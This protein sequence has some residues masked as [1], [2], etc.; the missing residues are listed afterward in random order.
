[1]KRLLFLAFALCVCSTRCLADVCTAMPT[2]EQLG[3]S[4][5]SDPGCG[6]FKTNADRYITCPYDANYHKCINYSCESMGFT[7]DPGMENN[8]P[9]SQKSAWCKTVIPCLFDSNYTLCTEFLE[10]CIAHECN[11]KKPPE[12][13]SCSAECF[14]RDTTCET[15]TTPVCTDW[16]CNKNDEGINYHCAK[17]EIVDGESVAVAVSCTDP[18]KTKCEPDCTKESCR[19]A[20]VLP[21]HAVCDI[22][23][24]I[25]YS[26][27]K[28]GA[29][30]C[31]KWHCEGTYQQVGDHCES[32]TTC[33]EKTCAAVNPVVNAHGIAPCSSRSANCNIGQSVYTDWACNNGYHC[34]KEE[35]INGV[36]KI[37]SIT[38]NEDETCTSKGGNACKEDCSIQTCSASV[39]PPLNAKCTKNC[40]T[41]DI[42]CNKEEICVDWACDAGFKK[43]KKNG[44]FECEQI[45]CTPSQIECNSNQSAV[46]VADKA[47]CSA[48]CVRTQSDAN[49][50][51]NEICTAWNCIAGYHCVSHETNASGLPKAVSCDSPDKV[52]CYQNCNRK[53]DANIYRYNESNKPDNSS[54]AGVPCSTL[55]S[56]CNEGPKMYQGFVCNVGY[57]KGPTG[58]ECVPDLTKVDKTSPHNCQTGYTCTCQEVSVPSHAH[59]TSSCTPTDKFGITS[60]TVPTAFA[61]DEGYHEITDG[62]ACQQDCTVVPCT[63]AVKPSGPAYCINKCK[64]MTEQ[65]AEGDEV[66]TS[67][68]CQPGY[69]TQTTETNNVVTAVACVQDE[70]ST[71]TDICLEK[72]CPGKV[73]TSLILKN[74]DGKTHAEGIN[75]CTEIITVVANNTT[76]CQDT[77][78]PTDWICEEGY[79]CAKKTIDANNVVSIEPVD[80][81]SSEKNYCQKDV[82]ITTCVRDPLPEN[83]FWKDIN[84]MT[85]AEKADD[86]IYCVPVHA[87]GTEGTPVSMLWLC[88]TPSGEY[89]E[90]SAGRQFL[91][92]KNETTKTCDIKYIINTCSE[93]VLPKN[94]SGNTAAGAAYD[95][96]SSCTIVEQSGAQRTV[97]ENWICIPGFNK[98]CVDAN[99]IPVLDNE[100][101]LITE[102]SAGQKLSCIRQEN[103]T[104]NTPVQKPS[105][106]VESNWCYPVTNGIVSTTGA[107]TDWVCEAGYHCAKKENNIVTPIELAPGEGCYT[108]GGNLCAQTCY[109]TTNDCNEENYPYAEGQLPDNGK[110][111]G[112]GLSCIYKDSS[113]DETKTVTRYK[114]VKCKNPYETF[115]NNTQKCTSEECSVPQNA[116]AA[117]AT[118]VTTP[119]SSNMTGVVFTTCSKNLYATASSSPDGQCHTQTITTAW[120][121]DSGFHCVNE[122]GNY[123]ECSS[124]D[125]VKCAL[126]CPNTSYQQGTKPTCYEQDGTSVVSCTPVCK[127]YKQPTVPSCTPQEKVC[128]VYGCP[129]TY[130]SVMKNGV[131]T[132]VKDCTPNDCTGQKVTLPASGHAHYRE[133]ALCCP[134]NTSC[135][136]T[137]EDCVPTAWDCD[138]GY[139]ESGGACLPDCTDNYTSDSIPEGQKCTTDNYPFTRYDS[140]LPPNAHVSETAGSCVPTTTS[141]STMQTLYK[142]W[143]C[144]TGFHCVDK[145]DVFVDN[146][147]S[148]PVTVS[149]SNGQY[150]DGK[151][152]CKKDCEDTASDI[153]T[154]SRFP[155]LENSLK[156][157]NVSRPEHSHVKKQ[158]PEG[159]TMFCTPQHAN[160]LTETERF[161]AWE[162]DAGYICTDSAGQEISCD[163]EQKIN[164]CE[165]NE[166]ESFY[167]TA[168]AC[169]KASNGFA[170][171]QQVISNQ[172]G[173][174]C[175][176][177]SLEDSPCVVGYYKTDTKPLGTDQ[178]TGETIVGLGCMKNS[179]TIYAPAIE[180]NECPAGF[181]AQQDGSC[182]EGS[183]KPSVEKIYA[184]YGNKVASAEVR[185]TADNFSRTPYINSKYYTNYQNHE[186]YL[187]NDMTCDITTYEQAQ[188]NNPKYS[189]PNLYN[190][191]S[192]IGNY[193]RVCEVF[194][195]AVPFGFDISA[196]TSQNNIITSYETKPCSEEKNQNCANIRCDATL[197]YLFDPRKWY[198]DGYNSTYPESYSYPYGYNCRYLTD[199][200]SCLYDDPH[201]CFAKGRLHNAAPYQCDE[202]NKNCHSDYSDCYTDNEG[203]KVCGQTFNIQV[204]SDEH[205]TEPQTVSE[206]VDSTNECMNL[207]TCADYEI[208]NHY[209]MNLFYVP[210]KIGREVSTPVC[211]MS[212]SEHHCDTYY[213]YASCAPGFINFSSCSYKK[214]DCR[215]QRIWPVEFKLKYFIDRRGNFAYKLAYRCYVPGLDDRYKNNNLYRFGE[216]GQIEFTL[217]LKFGNE[218]LQ[219]REFYVSCSDTDVDFHDVPCYS[220]RNDTNCANT[221]VPGREED[222]IYYGTGI[223][224]A[225]Y[226][227]PEFSL[228]SVYQS[229]WN[230]CHLQTGSYNIGK[231]IVFRSGS[232]NQL[233]AYI[234]PKD[235]SDPVFPIPEENELYSYAKVRSG[236]YYE[237]QSYDYSYDWETP[238]PDLKKSYELNGFH[239]RVYDNQGNIVG[240]V[241]CPGLSDPDCTVYALDEQGNQT[242]QILGYVRISNADATGYAEV[243]TAEGQ[244][245]GYYYAPEIFSDD[246]NFGVIYASQDIAD[247]YLGLLDNAEHPS[248]GY[249]ITDM[250]IKQKLND[251]IATPVEGSPNTYKFEPEKWNVPTPGQTWLGI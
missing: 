172:P 107:L 222:W 22:P 246:F 3:Y 248:D 106:A 8:P 66:C 194:D 134:Q 216:N 233:P 125:K 225:S 227:K 215:F 115:D 63:A 124:A 165:C 201:S 57:H 76:T 175:Y 137:S 136:N 83:A 143:V 67:W 170:C 92:E 167:N 135:T 77:P 38:L 37:T 240:A 186:Y 104:C 187:V 144:D 111:E 36:T 203:Q 189:D 230:A 117:G 164:T 9:K 50:S 59:Q 47:R 68:A 95:L 108:K 28:Q 211:R 242:Y 224:T 31:R 46:S 228:H 52:S 85:D 110:T 33:E 105:H 79:H 17:D 81:S 21:E 55:D 80:C 14:S 84:S 182:S 204:A 119:D 185:T 191:E 6:D 96:N 126:D 196:I 122:S 202:N 146:C 100:N 142:T 195:S 102:C 197:M 171:H 162:C 147:A 112:S 114:S 75:L 34:A 116:C 192:Q 15:N 243:H 41:Q 145:N 56:D 29:T 11:E 231:G 214:A 91:Y 220:I 173:Y 131:L 113:C 241:S 217:K 237:G 61:C 94:K 200:E 30:L 132:C 99:D 86:K 18:S 221:G 89:F 239:D 183:G 160:C 78:V 149:D 118:P 16:V 1:M 10:R 229:E 166:N 169:T 27:C 133:R 43:V 212:L 49:C 232:I 64:S 103:L 101:N 35:Q 153:C 140:L 71:N 244:S 251:H 130:H 154:A 190:R 40:I 24:T 7:H 161:K 90:D 97:Y 69:H 176:T 159:I 73:D 109:S 234:S 65:C 74:D 87:D 5:D 148:A 177:Y 138:E 226:V 236:K 72:T 12:H 180:N 42:N 235:G 245:T 128:T 93:V 150:G 247:E 4:K 157:G 174:G 205:S 155:Y 60:F 238:Q 20:V 152:G 70:I 141:C 44:Q 54:L 156:D 32:P 48:Q 198:E 181:L 121:C 25:R 249:C 210:Y 123:V 13:A 178:T 199:D 206:C 53:C 51:T 139:H 163:S 250:C 158:G 179:C 62:V 223:T 208:E 207:P 188:N 26:N 120:S 82:D 2:C 19:D 45:Q 127:E 98:G 23:C 218:E 193:N 129:G 88:P 58:E 219:D 168:L 151:K 213:E 39:T 209:D 184:K